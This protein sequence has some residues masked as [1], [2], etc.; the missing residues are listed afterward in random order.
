MKTHELTYKLHSRYGFLR[1]PAIALCMVQLATFAAIKSLGAT[2][3]Q[4][5]LVALALPV[6][7]LLALVCTGPLARFRRIPLMTLFEALSC[8]LLFPV[9]VVGGPLWFIA[10]VGISITARVLSFPPLAG[11]MRDNYHPLRRAHTL[12]KVQA[13]THGSSAACGILFGAV[14]DADPEAWRYLYPVS[15]LLGCVAVLQL[16]RIPEPDPAMRRFRSQ[17]SFLDFFRV[18]RKDRDFLYFQASFFIFGL[19]SMI[20]TILLP[21]YLAQELKAD[22]REGALALVTITSIML[23]V[24]SGQWGKVIDRFNVLFLRGFFNLLWATAPLLVFLTGSISGVYIGQLVVG[25]IQ[26]GSMLIWNLGINIFAPKDEVPTYM[27][28]HQALTG[29][30]G[31]MAPFLGIFLAA[32]LAPV[33]GLPN[34]RAVFLLCSI[35]MAAAGLFMIWEGRNMEKSGRATTFHKAEENDHR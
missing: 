27:A 32:W 29:A 4:A 2:E 30:R 10:L 20:Y 31:L 34:Y 25:L 19:A 35:V 3:E 8:A 18:L 33:G 26:G 28:I 7:N 23:V 14:M 16:L 11:L 1:G 5:I 17:P 13:W 24:T 9:A 22:Y 6:G 12:G 15:G 21:I